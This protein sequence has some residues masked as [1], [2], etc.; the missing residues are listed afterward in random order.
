ML[1]KKYPGGQFKEPSAHLPAVVDKLVALG[2]VRA[3]SNIL[4]LS[5]I[6]ATLLDLLSDQGFGS[7]QIVDF[8]Q[9]VPWQEN[10]GLETMQSIVSTPRFALRAG[11]MYG[12]VD[13]VCARFMLEHA[14]SAFAFLN[15]LVELVRPGGHLMVEVPDAGKML[16]CGNHALIWEDHFTYFSPSSLLRL[17]E[18]IGVLPVDF[19]VY[20]YSYEDAIVAILRVDDTK[21]PSQA[22]ADPEEMESVTEELKEFAEGFET[23]KAG[24]REILE[25]RISAGE[26]M[27]LFGAGHH[28][29]KYLNFYDFADLIEYAIDDNPTKQSLYLPGTDIIIK[30]SCFLMESELTTC[31]SSLSPESEFKVRQSLATF[32]ERGGQFIP[33]FKMERSSK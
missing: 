9:M 16:A 2:A 12:K 30:D 23:R 29:T 22:G 4:G 27:A 17:I 8:A 3:D 26:R 28:S 11:D 7:S 33:I 1:Q 18:A 25:Q 14:E 20:P 31:L 21:S 10:F 19:S 6:D 32:F 5:Y 24:L 13:L 15:S